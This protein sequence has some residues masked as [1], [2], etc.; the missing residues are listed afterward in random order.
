MFTVEREQ[1][2]KNLLK[3]VNAREQNRRGLSYLKTFWP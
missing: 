2:A 3:L 1:K